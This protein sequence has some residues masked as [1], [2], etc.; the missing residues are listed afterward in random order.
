MLLKHQKN[1]FVFTQL[2]R[3]KINV[4]EQ[5]KTNFKIENPINQFSKPN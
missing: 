2:Y 1:E 4:I 3:D 5:E